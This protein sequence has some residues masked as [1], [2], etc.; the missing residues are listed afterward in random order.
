MFNVPIS[1]LHTERVHIGPSLI[2]GITAH[3]GQAGLHLRP[4]GAT[5]VMHG[6]STGIL[7]AGQVDG[8]EANLFPIRGLFYMAALGATATV[9]I[10]RF[11]TT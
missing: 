5:M 4:I 3:Q 9:N 1:A 7:T 2:L 8:S 6:S 11:L 10:T